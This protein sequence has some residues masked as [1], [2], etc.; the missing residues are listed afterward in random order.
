MT[1]K[2]RAAGGGSPASFGGAGRGERCD[3][4]TRGASPARACSSALR[5]V[6]A[7]LPI[8][9]ALALPAVPATAAS[10]DP[11]EWTQPRAPLHLLGPITYVGTRGLGAYLIRT[12]AGA[13]L[14]DATMAEN[15]PAIE[16]NIRSL[17][18]KLSDVKYILVSH[19]HF[20]HVGGLER[21]RRD[22][23]ARVLAGRGDVAAL[24][25]GT[26]PGETNYG[27]VRFAPV[28]QVSPVDD[29]Q[30]V[31]LGGVTLRA[32]ATPGHTPGCTSWV[33]QVT[34]KG[35]PLQVV[36]AGSITVA[37][38]TLVGNRRYPS[39]V[40]DYRATFDRVE[41]LRADVVLPMHPESADVFER[42]RTG[43]LVAPGLL[44]ATA[45]ESRIAFERTLR[46]EEKPR[47]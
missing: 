4:A 46:A 8:A 13:I 12:S 9:A 22:T 16:R 7:F 31:T 44:R 11:P 15:V 17:G 3:T 38:N 6:G 43:R 27:V 34:D 30:R 37:G 45:R 19:A 35:R 36:F 24:R 28:A 1:R 21:M 40:R 20:D 14:V 10:G 33:M 47:R 32:V 18:V 23:G 26:P 41:R 5:L 25:A 2:Q 39:I 29:G 42:A